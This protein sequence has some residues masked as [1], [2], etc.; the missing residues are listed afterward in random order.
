MSSKLV[1]AYR[2]LKPKLAIID[3]IWAMQGQ[4]PQSLFPD[5]L[6]KNMNLIMASEDCVAL[7]AVATAVMGFD[8]LEI[9]TTRI[10]NYEGLGVGN[11]ND[12]EVKGVPI[13]AIKRSFRRPSPDI[14]A[15]YPNVDVYMHG[16]CEGCTHNV[17]I[18]LDKMAGKGV[19]AKI[20]KPINLILGFNT[21]VPESLDSERTWVIGDCARQN[22]DK[23]RAFFPGCPHIVAYYA[24]PLSVE[25]FL[26]GEKFPDFSYLPHYLRPF[27]TRK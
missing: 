16:G 20:D 23:G 14:V 5:D 26:Q 25:A 18:G 2:V 15:V 24:L 4:G 13:E 9:E 6:L 27:E 8:P 21:H 7:D 17:R 10:A 12:I 11:L 22:M 19:I 3:A 1:D